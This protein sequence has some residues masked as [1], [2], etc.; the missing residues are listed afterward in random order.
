MPDKA[1]KKPTP[2]FK[3]TV[4]TT[5]DAAVDI[6]KCNNTKCKAQADAQMKY[7]QEYSKR[8][9]DVFNQFYKKKITQTQFQKRMKEMTDEMLNSKEYKAFVECSLAK[10]APK[11]IKM[12][13]AYLKMFEYDCKE[14]K[15]KDSCTKQKKAGEILKKPIDYDSY[16]QM[17]KLMLKLKM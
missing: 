10:C 12:F 14:H 7:S 15:N 1:A 2:K 4:G 13:E 8:V 3:K 17:V 5:L 11:V 16:T 6:K 9:I